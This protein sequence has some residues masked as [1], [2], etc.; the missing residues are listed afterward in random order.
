M[1]LAEPLGPLAVA[2]CWG[3]R[4]TFHAQ[5]RLLDVF[6]VKVKNGE[7]KRGAEAPTK[8]F[9]VPIVA[10]N[11]TVGSHGNRYGRGQVL[12]FTSTR[13]RYADVEKRWKRNGCRKQG[14]GNEVPE[15]EQ[16]FSNLHGGRARTPQAPMGPQPQS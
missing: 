16:D 14:A 13:E 7:G 8:K 1:S 6:V 9:V 5:W 15:N 3:R 11:G 4:S 10:F 12:P 2:V